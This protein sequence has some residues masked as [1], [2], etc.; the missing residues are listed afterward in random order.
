[1]EE[2]TPPGGAFQTGPDP[3]RVLKFSDGAI[4]TVVEFDRNRFYGPSR[5]MTTAQPFVPSRV[6][7]DS[8]GNLFVADEYSNS[9]YKLTSNGKVPIVEG[10]KSSSSGGWN[11][12]PDLSR[13]NSQGNMVVDSAGNL[14]VADQGNHRVC[15]VT[16]DGK[17]INIAG[18]G[19]KGFSGDDGPA[20][21]ARLSSPASVA[22][23][24]AGHVYIADSGNNRI[25]KVAQSSS[26]SSK[27]PGQ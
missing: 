14:Y 22:L 5:G 15:K 23:D 19:Q 2:D 6:A 16:P 26:Q 4:T 21:A 25:R 7:V 13:L 12:K 17:I 10:I 3:H 20:T 11:G 8:A 18:T 24:S 27:K 1:V 9:L